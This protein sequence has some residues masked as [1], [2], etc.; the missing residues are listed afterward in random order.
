MNEK[1]IRSVIPMLIL[2]VLIFFWEAG[3]SASCS[4]RGCPI[5]RCW[6]NSRRKTSV[7]LR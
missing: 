7:A 2:L 3:C 1:R 5:L 6:S 4:P